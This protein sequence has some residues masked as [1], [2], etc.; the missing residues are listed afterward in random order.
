MYTNTEVAMVIQH[1]DVDPFERQV[2]GLIEMCK[3]LAKA[4]P[5]EKAVVNF[6]PFDENVVREAK[7]RVGVLKKSEKMA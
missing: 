2:E 1:T 3:Y 4:S 7:R 6:L 5:V